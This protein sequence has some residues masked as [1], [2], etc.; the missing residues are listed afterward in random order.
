MS[1]PDIDQ[2]ALR[3]Q[4]VRLLGSLADH[5]TPEEAILAH[6]VLA[7]LAEV[8]RLRAPFAAHAI[9]AELEDRLFVATR[10]LAL[11]HAQRDDHWSSL[12]T[13]RA[14]IAR[15]TKMQNP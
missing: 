1:R 10:D 9:V 15:L 13:A 6:G 4:A 8:E 14:E 3:A 5:S 12:L 2:E 11:A 7:L